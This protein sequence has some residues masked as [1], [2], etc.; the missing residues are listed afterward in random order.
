MKV[1]Q[2]WDKAVR[3]YHW[4]QLV[5]LLGL[6]FTAEQGYLVVHQILAYALAALLLSRLVWGFIGSD[7]ARFR[8][9]LQS[10][11]QLPRM[12]NKAKHGI[13][14]QGLSGYMSVALMLLL[15][16]QFVS[17]LMTTDD[18][19]TEGPLYS[20]VSS[21]WSSLASWLHHNNFDLLLILIAL[22][23]AAALF[24]GVRKDGVLGAMVH[25]K[26]KTEAAQPVVKST[27]WYLLLVLIFAGIFVLWQGV[28]LYQQW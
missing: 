9:F 20:K 21:D 16:L 1:I 6:W 2:L 17:G 10:P 8:H 22:H 7:T 25:G 27:F 14:H 4:S 15:L 19:L 23:V 24:H 18:V 5:L 28:A 26:L 12:W 3:I 13:G 11:A